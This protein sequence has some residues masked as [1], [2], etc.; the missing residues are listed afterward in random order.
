MRVTRS[1]A[2]AGIRLIAGAE[3]RADISSLP[4]TSPHRKVPSLADLLCYG[5]DGVGQEVDMLP[6][7]K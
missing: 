3:L 1:W 7:T 6:V 5:A 2:T 4:V